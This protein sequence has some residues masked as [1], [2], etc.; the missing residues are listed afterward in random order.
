[1]FDNFDTISFSLRHICLRCIMI[2]TNNQNGWYFENAYLVSFKF[3]RCLTCICSDTLIT[4]FA[5]S[6]T[7]ISIGNN[8]RN[9]HEI[10]V[11]LLYSLIILDLWLYNKY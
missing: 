2:N 7:P 1:M 8:V 6:G 9:I 3:E 5:I 10:K 4:I 11:G